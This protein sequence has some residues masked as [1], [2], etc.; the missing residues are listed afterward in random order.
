MCSENYKRHRLNFDGETLKLHVFLD[1]SVIEVFAN[2]HVCLT[3]R[4]Y[5]SRIDS[6]RI[7]FFTHDGSAKVKS[8]NI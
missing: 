2:S 4:I 6:L 3:G 5:P 8:M 7:G 1:R